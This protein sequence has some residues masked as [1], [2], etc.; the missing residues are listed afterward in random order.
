M[1]KF[2]SCILIIV[3]I[4]IPA[5][6]SANPKTDLFWDKA[7]GNIDARFECAKNSEPELIAFIRQMPKGADLHNH[8]SGAT[9]SDYLLDSAEKN[10]L[11]YDLGTNLFFSPNDPKY[12]PVNPI[13][14]S[15]LESNAVYL[16]QYLNIY[17]MRGWYPNTTNGHDQFFNT[18]NYMSSAKRTSDDML[19]EVINRNIYENVK[20]LE[21]MTNSLP[22]DYI[23]LFTNTAPGFDINKLD[24]AYNQAMEVIKNNQ[25]VVNT[26]IKSL[27]DAR[28]KMLA[29]SGISIGPGKDIEVNYIQQLYRSTNDMRSFFITA[30]YSV[31]ATKVDKRIVGVNI[32]QAEDTPYS[33]KYFDAEM[34]IMDY[35]WNKMGKPS[36]AIHAGELD[37]NGSPVEPMEDR[38]STTIQKG[39]ALRIGHGVSIAWE[40]NVP[41][42]LKEMKEKNILVEICL[43]SNESILGV[44]DEEHP[45][46]MY[47][48]AGVKTALST[49][50]EGVSRGNL[51][52]EYVK[53]IQ[54]YDLSYEDV[55]EL[56][57]NSL[58]YSFLPGQSLYINGDYTKIRKEFEKIWNVNYKI[59]A[60]VQ[61]LL[62][63]NPKMER[64]YMLERAYAMFENKLL[65]G[66]FGD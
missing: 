55:K 3:V 49:D 64:E 59:T 22:N 54:R 20:Y 6:V 27:L 35:I 15:Q 43:S 38:I 33:R 57:R 2:I 9:Y 62:A 60:K 11:N 63:E 13:T 5:V 14:I 23:N 17:S 18:F 1:K 24:E 10:G 32:V 31:Y 58:E 46:I 8:L 47:R 16:A 4:F 53:A 26:S 45:F 40:K 25:S 44:E 30:F 56:S 36:F 19:L 42:L 34:K 39:H 48:K 7:A 52:E 51:T 61:K 29:D 37:L 12:K 65:T 28:E 21:L 41:K 66:T 50:D